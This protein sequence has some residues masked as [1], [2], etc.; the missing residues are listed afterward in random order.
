MLEDTAIVTKET[1]APNPSKIIRP[2]DLYDSRFERTPASA[3][4][5]RIIDTYREIARKRGIKPVS[6]GTWLCVDG[7]QYD[8]LYREPSDD[9]RDMNGM[10]RVP[11]MVEERAITS[12]ADGVGKFCTNNSLVGCVDETGELLIAK[13]TAKNINTLKKAGYKEGSI[14]LYFSNGEIPTDPEIRKLYFNL[15]GWTEG[16]DE[17]QK[18]RME[19]KP[20]P[21]AQRKIET[22]A[23]IVKGRLKE[24]DHPE[25][26][27]TILGKDD[28]GNWR[29]ESK[30]WKEWDLSSKE[31]QPAQI[32]ITPSGRDYINTHPGLLRSIQEG[33]L[34]SA[35]IHENGTGSLVVHPRD[36]PEVMIKYMRFFPSDT[37]R[38]DQVVQ[39]ATGI[40]QL[41][42][43][44][45]LQQVFE[46]AGLHMS[47][48][49]AATRD[50]LVEEYINGEKLT[51]FLTNLRGAKENSI[52]F[53]RIFDELT[54]T[55]A[56]E[57]LDLMKREGQ[58]NP[59]LKRYYP[60]VIDF[61]LPTRGVDLFVNDNGQID[62][63][64][65][66]LHNWLAVNTSGTQDILRLSPPEQKRWLQEHLVLIDPPAKAAVLT[67]EEASRYRTQSIMRGQTGPLKN[68]AQP[69]DDRQD[70]QSTD[71][72]TALA[73]GLEEMR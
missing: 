38:E 11:T 51:D 54:V 25:W 37:V 10:V 69:E 33:N 30:T 27:I 63:S 39:A 17:D 45:F 60:S 47:R 40:D 19:S 22:A 55:A 24:V 52:A 23:R 50:M 73:S 1:L 4:G 16:T 36:W 48:T 57:Y 20:D 2:I 31:Y 14:P 49:Y 21:E 29:A 58:K 9:E 8:Y 61:V 56:K 53:L 59:Q 72:G 5:S 41:Y 7:I 28:Y 13:A 67:E 64:H 44:T 71:Q 43:K 42:I 66:S 70:A 35:R 46:P 15:R 26:G 62:C 34:A 12:R 6:E 18:S 3:R 68:I 65:V 32:I